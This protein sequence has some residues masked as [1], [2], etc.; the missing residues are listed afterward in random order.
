MYNRDEVKGKADAMAG[1]IKQATAK[2]TND[3]HLQAEGEAQE[4]GGV[5]QGGFGKAR[6]KVGEAIKQVGDAVKK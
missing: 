6:R 3:Q 2:L 5:A 1:R 4:A